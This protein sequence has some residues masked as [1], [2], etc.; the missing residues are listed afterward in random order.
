MSTLA[1]SLNDTGICAC[2]PGKESLLPIDGPQSESP[3]YAIVHKHATLSGVAAAA[4]SS[5]QPLNVN[6]RFW[7]QLNAEGN[8]D[9]AC[10]HLTHL[11]SHVRA[12]V[13]T[14]LFSVPASWTPYQLGLLH[15][16]CKEIGLPVKVFVA[17]P[18]LATT[19]GLHIEILLHRTVFSIVQD[20]D[21]TAWRDAYTAS[22]QGGTGVG[23][24]LTTVANDLVIMF[25]GQYSA[26]P[27]TPS[28]WTSI[29]A[30]TTNNSRGGRASYIVATGSTQACDA[31]ATVNYSGVVAISIPEAAGGGGPSI[32]IL[33][34]HIRQQS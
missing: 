3:G 20:G 9:L 11:W 1:I 28:G 34:H 18:V 24:T 15:G 29:L 12:G 21:L 23:V 32:P 17:A 10:A 7:D 8:G 19:T 4:Q 30:A 2:N 6:H 31:Q 14:V 13:D 16:I 5:I 27:A 22:A 25:D 26:T 33:T